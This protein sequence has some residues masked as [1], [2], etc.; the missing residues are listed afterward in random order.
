MAVHAK[1]SFTQH[2]SYYYNIVLL[3][4]NNGSQANYL[5]HLSMPSEACRAS[6]RV[7]EGEWRSCYDGPVVRLAVFL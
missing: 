2:F 3:W 5:D 4:Y 6:G 7:V 1:I